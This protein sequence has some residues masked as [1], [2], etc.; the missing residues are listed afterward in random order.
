MCAIPVVLVA[1]FPSQQI[2][3]HLFFDSK[4]TIMCEKKLCELISQNISTQ[5]LILLNSVKLSICDIYYI[6]YFFK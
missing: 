5:A 2:I 4:D 6:T 3:F 1:L